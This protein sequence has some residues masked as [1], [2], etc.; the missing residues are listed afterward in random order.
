MEPELSQEC[1]VMRWKLRG[2]WM[3]LPAMVALLAIGTGVD[4]SAGGG[5]DTLHRPSVDSI[6][7]DVD[8]AY[9]IDGPS[10]RPGMAPGAPLPEVDPVPV[11]S[12]LRRVLVYMAPALQRASVERANVK[13]FATEVGGFVKYEYPVVMPD[14]LNLRGLTDAD[15]E[16]LKVMPGVVKV[17]EDE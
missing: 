7:L 5:N 1:V 3:W 17:E 2:R 6:P 12:E 4:W 16:A 15:V 13:A 9:W 14:V 11:A 8:P 10:F